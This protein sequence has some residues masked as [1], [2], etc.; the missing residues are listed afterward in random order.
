MYSFPTP[1]KGV[2]RFVCS[3]VCVTSPAAV[4]EVFDK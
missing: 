1:K 4:P 3:R 2:L